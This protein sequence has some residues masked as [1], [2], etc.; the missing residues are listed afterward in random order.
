[1]GVSLP[2]NK[3]TMADKLSAMEHLWDDLGARE[4]RARLGK[5]RFVSIKEAKARIRKA[6]R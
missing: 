1:M 6:I 2:L 4:R 5:A 3:M